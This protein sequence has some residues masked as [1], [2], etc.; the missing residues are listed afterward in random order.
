MVK[1]FNSLKIIFFTNLQY[2]TTKDKKLKKDIGYYKE[3]DKSSIYKYKGGYWQND[4][5]VYIDVFKHFGN[6]DKTKYKIN[7]KQLTTVELKINQKVGSS[8]WDDDD[9]EE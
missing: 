6:D 8:L 1:R 9:D 7:L 2:K 4:E 5:T 3:I